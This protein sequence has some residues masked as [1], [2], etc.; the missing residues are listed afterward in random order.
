M[1]STRTTSSSIACS[2]L[3][4]SGW[5]SSTLSVILPFGRDDDLSE[6]SLNV[7][8]SSTSPASNSFSSLA[9]AGDDSS[10]RLA[11]AAEMSDTSGLVSAAEEVGV[12]GG[13]LT[14]KDKESTLA[15]CARTGVVC[16]FQRLERKRER[17]DCA[18]GTSRP[19]SG[20]SKVPYGAEPRV[21][22]DGA[23]DF[24]MGRMVAKRVCSL[25]DGR[26]EGDE[27]GSNGCVSLR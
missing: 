8:L 22:T 11:T 20:I 7:S 26:K 6:R 1:S 3:P 25:K 19:S 21:S 23:S 4:C 18:S 2:R 17:K 12:G 16:C 24:G 27:C 10:S 15:L 14:G 5:Q 13:G 9:S